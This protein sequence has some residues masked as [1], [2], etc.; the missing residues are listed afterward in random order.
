MKGVVRDRIDIV[1]GRSAVLSADP[2]D[3]TRGREAP[4]WG[5]DGRCPGPGPERNG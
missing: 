5:R 4:A 1:T 2:A 3:P